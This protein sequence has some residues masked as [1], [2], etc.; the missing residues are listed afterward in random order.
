MEEKEFNVISIHRVNEIRSSNFDTVLHGNVM[1][2]PINGNIEEVRSS[3]IVIGGPMGWPPR[4]A[5]VKGW[6]IES[7]QKIMLC[8]KNKIN[9]VILFLLQTSANVEQTS[10][11]KC[12]RK[13]LASLMTSFCACNK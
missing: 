4:A 9:S 7:C 1:Q 10:L 2:Y 13:V 3:G 8:K 11:L 5:L 6:H 12:F